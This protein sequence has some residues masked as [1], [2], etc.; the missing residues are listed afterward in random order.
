MS[1]PDHCFLRDHPFN[2]KGG[3]GAI[4]FFGNKYLC[5][6]MWGGWDSVSD[7]DM[8]LYALKNI[9]F[10]QAVVKKKIPLHHEAKKIISTPKKTLALS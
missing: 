10:V 2:L 4:V 9:A 3:R 7:M 5:Q 6:Q 1:L 8:A